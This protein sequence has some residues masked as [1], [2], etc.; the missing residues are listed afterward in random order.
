MFFNLFVILALAIIVAMFTI[1]NAVPVTVGLIFWKSQQVSLAVVILVSVMIG[2]IFTAAIALYQKIKDG[3]KIYQLEKRIRELEDA[4][5]A[6]VRSQQSS[7]D[8]Q[9]P[10]V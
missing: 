4:A 10:N 7:K 8:F 9:L 6:P 2:V 1:S 3:I 5:A